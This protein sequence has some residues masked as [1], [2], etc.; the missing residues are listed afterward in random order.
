MESNSYSD[1]EYNQ[2]YS[3]INKNSKFSQQQKSSLIISN[4]TTFINQI[5]IFLS[6]IPSSSIRFSIPWTHLQFTKFPSMDFLL[7]IIKYILTI[8]NINKVYFEKIK[9]IIKI[10]Y[11][12]NFKQ[13][14]RSVPA[15][16]AVPF[17]PGKA[18]GKRA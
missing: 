14:Y 3:T 18:G 10:L 13:F 9:A 8:E 17:P 6:S 16:R 1:Q 7:D 2:M 4:K 5:K 11:K 15:V 12:N